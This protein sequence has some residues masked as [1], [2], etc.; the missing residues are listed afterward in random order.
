MDRTRKLVC[1]DRLKTWLGAFLIS[2]FLNTLKGP[3]ELPVMKW[4]GL[5]RT[6]SVRVRA[7]EKNHR[8]GYASVCTNAVPEELTLSV[9]HR[10]RSAL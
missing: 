9:E 3:S 10:A 2:K 5:Q 7:I 8:L 1:V 6:R 4:P